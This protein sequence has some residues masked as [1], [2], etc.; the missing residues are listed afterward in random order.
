MMG[1]TGE[2]ID[3]SETQKL[4]VKMREMSLDDKDKCI[5]MI[6]TTLACVP[7]ATPLNLMCP[8]SLGKRH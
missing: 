6:T 4:K 3:G 7:H 1:G 5:I 2:L 8:I